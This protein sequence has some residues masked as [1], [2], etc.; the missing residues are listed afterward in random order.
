V[1]VHN[2]RGEERLNLAVFAV[3]SFAAVFVLWAAISE[4]FRPWLPLP[5]W[6]GPDAHN[7]W[8]AWRLGLY[9]GTPLLYGAGDF[10]Y[11]P[12]AAQFLWPITWLPYEAFR[13]LL[14]IPAVLAFG[15]M[16]RPAT[17]PIRM[18][19]GLLAGFAVVIG[20]IE[21]LFCLTVIFAVEAPWAWA[22]ALLTK[23]TPG[24]GVLWYVGARNL[25]GLVI[26]IGSTAAIVAISYLAA[27]SL[28]ADWIGLLRSNANSHTV[29]WLL[30]GSWLPLW[31]RL[32]PAGALALVAG[33]RHSRLIL[34]AAL[35]LAQPDPNPSTLALLCVLPRVV[36]PARLP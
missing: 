29:G 17:W 21:W 11:S 2:P 20:N 34:M 31:I 15:W 13:V 35:Y 14:A 28:W 19:L 24:V 23:V 16:L 25:R 8:T 7:Y 1:V 3:A 4:Y 33:R 10:L 36:A 30:L 32:V 22:V 18:S 6:V 5:W 27:S 9:H 26:A 12:A